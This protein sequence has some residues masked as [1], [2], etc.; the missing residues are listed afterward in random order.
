MRREAAGP[1]RSGCGV[2]AHRGSGSAL[3]SESR[4]EGGKCPDFSTTWRP[5]HVSDNRCASAIAD[6]MERVVL[7]GFSIFSVDNQLKSETKHPHR[8]SPDSIER[9][10][11]KN[12]VK[13][14]PFCRIF[15]F[16]HR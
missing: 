9:R 4:A 16:F 15:A 6:Y 5:G 1:R 14:K 3:W 13:R 10:G 11:L 8:Q 7:A 12:R 2:K